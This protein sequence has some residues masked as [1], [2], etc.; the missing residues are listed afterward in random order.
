[1]PI[2]IKAR[3]RMDSNDPIARMNKIIRFRSPKMV[4]ITVVDNAPVP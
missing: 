4:P 3:A 2:E 1:M